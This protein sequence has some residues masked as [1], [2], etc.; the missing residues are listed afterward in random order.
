M[1]NLL[2]IGAGKSGIAA[3]KLAITKEYN[4]VIT[5]SKSADDLNIVENEFEALGIKTEFGSPKKDILKGIDIVVVSPGVPPSS[6]LVKIAESRKI[7]VISELEFAYQ[8]CSNPVIA[9]TGTN[10][11][12]T[13]TALIEFMLNNS[14][15]KAL[16]CGNFGVP[17]S[18]VVQSIDNETILV[19]EVS[20]Y[21]LS[22]IRNFR[23]DVAVI[24]NITPD[25]LNYHG[26]LDAYVE[27][28]WKITLNQNE[29][30][31]LILNRDD[32]LIMK[33]FS[34]TRANA[35]FISMQS[36]N[37]GIYSTGGKMILKYADKEEVIMS[38]ADL[39]LPGIH[40][41]YNSMAA[42]LACRAFELSNEDIRDSLSK[43]NGVEHRLELVRTFHG[44]DFINDSKATNI[45]ATWY[46]LQAY[47]NPI[48][49][50]AGG[51]GD[52]N[53]YTALDEIV[54]KNVK[55]IIAF[56]E[57]ADNIFNHFC[58][59]K[60]CV[61]A[62]DLEEAVKYS[63]ATAEQGDKVVFTPACKSFDMFMNFEHRG[64][65][66]KNIVRQL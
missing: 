41:T 15:K 5:D 57:E 32:E 8:Y 46:A 2:I 34:K 54:Q 26:S 35:A 10:G 1:R 38:V 63:I 51:R 17:L 61:K 42:A 22:R 43:F 58:L 53:D 39:G 64:E 31:L 60:R 7:T 3:A 52:N 23:P 9:I 20:S 28:K 56:G 47:S 33:K 50:I 45:N 27:S 29:K 55:C 36:V 66:F 62:N 65:V 19:I 12:T 11:K 44:I 4:V 18:N 37:R 48:I 40:N 14:G 6:E 24:L 21:Q 16:A 13:T 59:M 49:W 25:H 30:N